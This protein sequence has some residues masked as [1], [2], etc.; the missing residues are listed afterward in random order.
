MWTA[1]ERNFILSVHRRLPIHI[2]VYI[3]LKNREGGLDKWASLKMAI[4]LIGYLSYLASK[5][6]LVDLND[7]TLFYV[8]PT[9]NRDYHR[10]LM[11]YKLA[12]PYSG[13]GRANAIVVD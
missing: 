2:I 9:A 13:N 1:A 6:L 7:D 4:H 12:D 11:L 8:F 3:L 10:R 5:K